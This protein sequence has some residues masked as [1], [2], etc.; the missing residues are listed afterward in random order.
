MPKQERPAGKSGARKVAKA[1]F[2]LGHAR[3]SKISAV[4]GIRLSPAMKERAAD[5]KQ[6]GLSADEYRRTIVQSH[7]KG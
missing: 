7:R 2:V 3:F 4:E 5:A 6:Q 1:G